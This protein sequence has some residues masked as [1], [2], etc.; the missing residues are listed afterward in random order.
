[1][2]YLDPDK[3][4]WKEL[5]EKKA[6]ALVLSFCLTSLASNSSVFDICML[7]QAPSSGSEKSSAQQV[8]KWAGQVQLAVFEAN[9]GVVAEGIAF[10]NGTSNGLLNSTLLGLTDPDPTYPFWKDCVSLP[11]HLHPLFPYKMLMFKGK[12]PVKGM[13]GG[14]HVLKR[15]TCQM[16]SGART[17]SWGACFVDLT[18]GLVGGMPSK[19]YNVADPQCDKESQYRLVARF[20]HGHWDGLGSKIN[21]FVGAMIMSGTISAWAYNNKER[22]RTMS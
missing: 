11:V 16:Q 19:A 18:N 9:G 21:A 10:D 1:M 7:P 6:S 3:V 15:L 17:I 13:N 14:F 12:Q 2:S 20:F 5:S 22:A 8:L 4:N